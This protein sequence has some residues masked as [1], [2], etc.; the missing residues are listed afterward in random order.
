MRAR[1]LRLVNHVFLADCETEAS[2]SFDR[3]FVV[4]FDVKDHFL[5]A[6]RVE[7]GQAHADEGNAKPA[8]PVG[9]VEAYYVDFAEAL[10]MLLCPVEADDLAGGG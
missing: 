3:R 10:G 4:R 7:V 1:L 9:G 2:V 8:T 5:A 6:Y